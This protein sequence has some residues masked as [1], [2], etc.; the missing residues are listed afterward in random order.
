MRQVLDE[1]CAEDVKNALWDQHVVGVLAKRDADARDELREKWKSYRDEP[2]SE[3]AA[4]VAKVEA[5]RRKRIDPNIKAI[6]ELLTVNNDFWE[7]G[8]DGRKTERLWKHVNSLTA[9]STDPV[10]AHWF[11]CE[12]A[13]DCLMAIYDIKRETFIED[14]L[15]QVVNMNMLNGLDEV[16]TPGWISRLSPEQI[17]RLAFEPEN[18]QRYREHLRTRLERLDHGQNTLKG[19]WGGVVI[20]N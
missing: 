16:I 7:G 18:V 4:Y 14:F 20:S 11:S 17:Q 9:A 12:Q 15:S 13:L 1:C 6:K 19:V 8:S 10:S 3:D 5:R 2:M